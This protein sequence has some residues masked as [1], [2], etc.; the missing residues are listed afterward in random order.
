MPDHKTYKVKIELTV[1]DVREALGE[2]FGTPTENVKIFLGDPNINPKAVDK[3]FM[4]VI[5]KELQFP[6]KEKDYVYVPSSP[7][8]TPAWDPMKPNIVW[9]GTQTNPIDISTSPTINA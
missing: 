6:E 7:L 5:E 8:T 9:C 4:M 1:Q 3:L 2:Y